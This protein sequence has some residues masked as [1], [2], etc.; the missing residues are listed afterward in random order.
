VGGPSWN[1]E[2]G[3]FPIL[4]RRRR[5]PI[6]HLLMPAL[7]PG[8]RTTVR[9]VRGKGDSWR[10]FSTAKPLDLFEEAWRMESAATV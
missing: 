9:E 10:R 8:K 6:A 3:V 2:A 7:R 1:E 5:L 4:L